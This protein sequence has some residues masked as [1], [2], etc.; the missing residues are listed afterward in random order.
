VLT[1]AQ[2]HRLRKAIVLGMGMLPGFLQRRLSKRPPVV[3]DGQRLDPA[4]QLLI[5]L[6]RKQ[7]GNPLTTGTPY[8]ARARYRRDS[9][10]V[11]GRP[12]SV[13]AV[14]DLSVDGAEGPLRARQYA[15]KSGSDGSLLLY[16]HGGGF[17]LGDLDTHDEV[18]RLLCRHAG[19]QVVSV[20]YRLAPE[21]PFPAAV[22]DAVAAV[23]WAQ[24][25]AGTLGIDPARVSVGGDSAG[26]NIA[27]VVAQRLARDSPPEAQLLI[28]PATDEGCGRPSESLFDAGYFLSMDDRRAFSRYYCDPDRSLGGDPRLHPLKGSDLGGLAPALVVTAGFDV[29]RDEG[30]EYAR[31]LDSAGTRVVLRREPSLGHGFIQLTGFSRGARRATIEMARSWRALLEAA[32]AS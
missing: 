24:R 25:T 20:E 26:G 21:H 7:L 4:L 5:S 1:R 30:E 9:L 8:E 19:Q 28:Y 23:R 3:I 2:K 32:R 6:R 31:A 13:G 14:R 16:F 17:L 10:M 27:A 22:D 18:C 15:P 11:Q 12:T 29:L